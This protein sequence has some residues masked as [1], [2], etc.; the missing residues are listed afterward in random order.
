MIILRNKESTWGFGGD[1]QKVN[2]R[3]LLLGA[4]AATKQHGHVT[5]PAT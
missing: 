2:P 4:E 3:I 5:S 1:P